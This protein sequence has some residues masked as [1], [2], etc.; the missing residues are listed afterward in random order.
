MQM[1]KNNPAQYIKR[2]DLPERLLH[3]KTEGANSTCQPKERDFSTA[4]IDANFYV[5]FRTKPN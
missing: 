1:I 5:T 4:Y 2:S 3:V